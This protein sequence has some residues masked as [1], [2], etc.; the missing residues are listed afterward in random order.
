MRAAN[1]HFADRLCAA[2]DRVGSPACV[3]LD[4][5]FGKLPAAIRAANADPPRAIEMFCLGALEAIAEHIAV[6][7]VQSA[8]FER[9]AGAGVDAMARIVFE[10]QRL[11]LIVILDAKR[12]DIGVSAQHYAAFAFEAMRA[13]ALTVSAYLG[14]DTLEPYLDPL[15][16]DRGLFVLVRTSNPESDAVQS[17]TLA[18]GRTVAE[19]MADLVV[20]AG[21]ERRGECGLSSV[22][23]VVAATKP[24]D[25]R[26]LR[27]R[28]SEQIF[29]VPGYGAQGGTLESVREMFLPDGRG[30]VVTAS[31]SVIDA[32]LA[33]EPSE[34]PG[35]GTPPAADWRDS[36]KAAATDFA[37]ELRQVADS[38][39]G[40]EAQR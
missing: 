13:D 4:P 31:R 24:G 34:H 7:K 9:F 28:M 14:S 23:A 22:G 16:A 21:H 17:R 19:M 6:V 11:G 15:Y 37:R 25:A 8:C 29:L 2:V 32:H 39:G 27:L 30:A 26:S 18:D 12:G 1:S 20:R 38:D 33:S 10:A 3:G 36:V 40:A 35:A 5:V